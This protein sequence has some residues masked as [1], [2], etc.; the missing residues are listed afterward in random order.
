MDGQAPVVVAQSLGVGMML[1]MN[2][3]M[4]TSA[5]ST[6]DSTFASFSKLWVID[7]K[8]GGSNPVSRGRIVM[9][10]LAV[11]GTI[12]VF[13]GPE[14]LSATT[15]S[16]TMVMGLAPVFLLWK[17]KAPAASFQLAVWPGIVLGIMLTA[18]LWPES[19]TFFPGKYGD[20]LSVNIVGLAIC[21]L[22]YVLP[23]LFQ[24]KQS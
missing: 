22:G 18:G 16:G 19:L 23:I 2:T 11:L 3:I 4:I 10:V 20:L 24:R 1:L 5:A 9:A 7:L 12:P 6:L 21:T 15:V 14:I 17:V 13:L 8:R